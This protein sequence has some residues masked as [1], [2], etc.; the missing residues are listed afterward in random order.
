VPD[1]GGTGCSTCNTNTEQLFLKKIA[2]ALDGS[3][4]SQTVSDNGERLRELERLNGDLQRDLDAL[5]AKFDAK[6]DAPA[7]ANG[8]PDLEAQIDQVLGII[9]RVDQVLRSRK[10]E[11]H[12]S[13]GAHGSIELMTYDSKSS[14]VKIAHP[15][16]CDLFALAAEL[17]VLEPA[18]PKQQSK[19]GNGKAAPKTATEST[20]NA[21]VPLLDFDCIPC[22]G[23]NGTMS[24]EAPTKTGA[25]T[26]RVTDIRGEG[27]WKAMLMPDQEELGSDFSNRESAE[28]A[29]NFHYRKNPN[30]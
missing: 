1:C 4:P 6:P 16:E 9:Q 5:Q 25:H 20:P 18:K 30:L 23:P 24:W 7:D 14:V 10:P 26:F 29:C 17:G 2:D 15:E 28:R 8:K 27:V 11:R 3:V 12:L 13:I 21:E 19:K 22:H